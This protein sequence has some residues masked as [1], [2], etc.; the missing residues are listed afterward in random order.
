MTDLKDKATQMAGAVGDL[1]KG[2][3]AAGLLGKLKGLGLGDLASSWVSKGKNLPISTD[4]IAKLLGSGTIA[5]I[6]AKLGIGEEQTA[7]SLAEALPD[8]I[9]DMT[10]DG[11]EPAEDAAPPDPVALT[12]KLFGGG[13]G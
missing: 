2:G 8:A 4:Q 13:G 10:P 3:G 9:D 5:S 1:L 6:A 12:R 11:N 7:K